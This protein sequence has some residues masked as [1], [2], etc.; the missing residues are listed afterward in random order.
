M[1]QRILKLFVVP[2]IRFS[3]LPIYSCFIDLMSSTLSSDK[4]ETDVVETEMTS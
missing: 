3:V 1:N 4:N 2:L